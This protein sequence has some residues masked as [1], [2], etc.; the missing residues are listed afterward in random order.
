M[1]VCPPHFALIDCSDDID[2]MSFNSCCLKCHVRNRNDIFLFSL[3]AE[4][5][6]SLLD[7]KFNW[8]YSS[9]SDNTDASLDQLKEMLRTKWDEAF[10][11]L[12]TEDGCRDAQITVTQDPNPVS[13]AAA[14]VYVSFI[15][16]KAP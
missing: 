11:D 15:V 16:T 2:V 7:V 13:G 1:S 10:V 4:K 12:C 6:V 9:N 8:S 5:C 14:E 3:F